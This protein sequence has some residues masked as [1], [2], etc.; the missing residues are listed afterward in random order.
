GVSIGTV[1]EPVPPVHQQEPSSTRIFSNVA[2]NVPVDSFL[3]NVLSDVMRPVKHLEAIFTSESA[4]IVIVLSPV[5]NQAS[6]RGACWI[7]FSMERPLRP[8]PPVSIDLISIR[9]QYTYRR[10][11]NGFR[12]T[13]IVEVPASDPT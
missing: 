3:S 7:S 2:S 11:I 6:V 12:S 10:W 1:I 13:V 4:A 9:S 5:P 8:A